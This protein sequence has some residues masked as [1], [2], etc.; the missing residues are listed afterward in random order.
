MPIFPQTQMRQS[1]FGSYNG[2][3]GTMDQ[4][5]KTLSRQQASSNYNGG[6]Q[7]FNN[8]GQRGNGNYRSNYKWR[9]SN[10]FRQN[11]GWIWNTDSR[12]TLHPEC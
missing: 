3:G 4:F 5:I 10:N 8:G 12:T 11:N 2:F 9:G 1:S 7:R 6:H